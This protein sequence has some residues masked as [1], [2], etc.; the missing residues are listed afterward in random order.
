[1]FKDENGETSPT[2]ITVAIVIGVVALIAFLILNPMVI[3]GAGQRGVVL[4]WGAVQ[5]K[6]L[7]PGIHWITPIAEAVEKMDVQTQKMEIGVLA[8]SKD[9]QTVETKIALNY[10]L[11]PEMVDKTWKEIGKDFQS[12]VIDPS[13]KESV[14]AATANFTAQELIEQRAKVKDVIK[15]EMFNRLS[16]YFV[17][18]DFS[19]ID[20]SFSDQYESAVE[21]KQVAQ[22]KAFEQEN[23][24]KQIEEQ[25]KQRV[26]TATA[27]AQAIKIQAEAVTQQGGADYVKLKAIE[28]WNGTVPTTM[29]P[30]STVPFLE[31]NK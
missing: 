3:V 23:I 13:V 11:K 19:I 21:S 12:R 9:I 4:K 31:L 27:E 26:T 28:K 29:V 25:A 24:T 15:T 6:V 2:K 30:G 18:D 1:M 16:N 10:H 22:Q 8:Y 5:D 17:V 20:F 14:K 7:N